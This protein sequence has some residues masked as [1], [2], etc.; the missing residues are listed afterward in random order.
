MSSRIT[1]VFSG[2]A[3]EHKAGLNNAAWLVK[4]RA[5]GPK[6]RSRGGVKVGDVN[7]REVSSNE[8]GILDV[9]RSH[10]EREGAAT[11]TVKEVGGGVSTRLN[12]FRP[13][14]QRYSVLEIVIDQER[15]T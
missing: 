11:R 2:G 3:S 7:D 6:G 15:A 12:V 9:G 1:F 10:C 14:G 4:F 13:G 5:G 8:E